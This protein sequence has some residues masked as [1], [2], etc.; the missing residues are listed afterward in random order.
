VYG[1]GEVSS[2]LARPVVTGLGGEER[3]S[4]GRPMSG[5]GSVIGEGGSFCRGEYSSIGDGLVLLSAR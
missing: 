1:W 5:E 2:A 4:G 3:G